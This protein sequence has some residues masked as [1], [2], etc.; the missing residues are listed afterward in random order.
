MK[1]YNFLFF[2]C[3]LYAI[4]S[5]SS[6]VSSALSRSSNSD[7]LEIL[8]QVDLYSEMGHRPSYDRFATVPDTF[9]ANYP[10]SRM[11]WYADS[12]TT[13]A[14][15]SLTPMPF[16][17]SRGLSNTVIVDPIDR[18]LIPSTSSAIAIP[19]TLS[20]IKRFSVKTRILFAFLITFNMIELGL[21]IIDIVDYYALPKNQSEKPVLEIAR[22][23]NSSMN[24]FLLYLLYHFNADKL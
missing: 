24:I 16:V 11:R 20:D 17:A 12:N 6:Q 3:A 10:N 18:E 4:A 9:N 5:Y 13:L 21:N 2:V 1:L 8:G 22:I 7:Q 15:N 19:D 23:A 14:T